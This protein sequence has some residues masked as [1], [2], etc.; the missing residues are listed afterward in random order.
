MRDNR[1]CIRAQATFCPSLRSFA[2]FSGVFNE[3]IFRLSGGFFLSSPFFYRKHAIVL[4]QD[5][6]ALSAD[7]IVLLFDLIN[8]DAWTSRMNIS[9]WLESL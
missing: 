3:N 8:H 6:N 2:R 4:F 7:E 9:V 1:V 5:L